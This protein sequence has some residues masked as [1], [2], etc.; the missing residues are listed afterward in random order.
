M[1]LKKSVSSRF[2]ELDIFRGLAISYMIFLHVLWDLDYFNI[3]P[4]HGGIYQFNKIVPLMFFMLIGICLS[5]SYSKK[6]QH[7]T[8]LMIRHLTLRG[9]WIIGLGMIITVVTLVFMPER[10][11]F[12]GVLHCIGL[13]II[14]TIPFMQLK[15]F[16]VIP[17]A[18]MVLI[19]FAISMF[20]VQNPSALHLIV[21]LHPAGFWRYTIDYF[22]LFPWLGVM[23]LGV[24]VGNLL[25]K[26]G[27]RQF[28]FPDFIAHYKPVSALSWMGQHSLIIYL[29]HQPVIAGI[30]GLYIVI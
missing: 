19:G 21:G 1:D 8:K 10:P 14:L 28:K 25:Y 12:F 13:S 17:G 7:D 3:L 15:K 18:V 5:I 4:L 30:L 6:Y 27:Q 20:S 9:L 24:A 22:P 29:I 26:N 2:P 23:L 11:I 16:N